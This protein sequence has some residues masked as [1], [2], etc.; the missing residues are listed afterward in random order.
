MLGIPKVSLGE[1]KG[2]LR[3]HVSVYFLVL[4][5]P[6]GSERG[7]HDDPSPLVML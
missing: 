5:W 3:K 7:S 4:G 6:L 2:N 1:P